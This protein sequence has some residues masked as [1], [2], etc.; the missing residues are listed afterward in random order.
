MSAAVDFLALEPLLLQ[1]LSEQ[2]L[3]EGKQIDVLPYKELPTKAGGDGEE[4]ILRAPSLIVTYDGYRVLQVSLNKARVQQQWTV[5][6]CVA[7]VRDRARAGAREDAGS[8][9]DQVITALLGWFPEPPETRRYKALEL[10]D[11]I[12]QPE[13]RQRFSLFPLTFIAER[14]VNGAPLT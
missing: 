11:P 13:Y 6:V 12:Y 2:V 14:P 3:V 7:N 1:R 5:A 10:A 4:P 9:I 8:I